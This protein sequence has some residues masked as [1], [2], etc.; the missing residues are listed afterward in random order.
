[1]AT[2]GDR[3][4]RAR[5]RKGLKQKEV[6]ERTGISDKSLSRYENNASEPDAESLVKLS[7]LYEVSLD[8]LLGK[9]I[10]K[11]S[12]NALPESEIERIVSE[13]E[14]EE[15]VKLR[16]NPIAHQAVRN[17]LELIAKALK[18]SE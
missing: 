17:A 11:R 18:S 5:D 3:L 12:A 16:D 7:N 13:I 15:N 6:N 8:W 4:R 9:E 10:K 1:M 2:L 14:V